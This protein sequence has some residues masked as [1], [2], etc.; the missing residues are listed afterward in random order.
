MCFN[1]SLSLLL[2]SISTVVTGQ[3]NCLIYPEDSGERLA[4]ELSYRAL[5]YPQGSAPSQLL[6]DHAIKLGP[7]YA[8]AYY[9]KSVPYFKRGML[10]QGIKLLNKA[11]ELDPKKHITYRAYWYFSN[12]NFN[13]CIADLERY[14]Y[15]LNGILHP[16]PGGDFEMRMLLAM[17]Y[18]QTG[19]MQKA[20]DLVEYSLHN[21]ESLGYFISPYDYHVLGMLYYFNRQFT[22]ASNAFQK[23][24]SINNR[25][26]DTYYY[27]ALTH[28]SMGNLGEV[29]TLLKE[30]L[31]RFD[32]KKDGFSF[33]AFANYNVDRSQVIFEISSERSK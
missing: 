9:E 15:Q 16:T 32:G 21:Y 4:C 23:Q 30:S 31:D 28:K 33:N 2:F 13:G 26:A 24:L 1:K 22:D 29:N 27:L 10:S 20:I 25:L 19:Q 11:I 17:S 3:G 14:Y 6:F 18:A 8:Y 5:E 12:H 7:D